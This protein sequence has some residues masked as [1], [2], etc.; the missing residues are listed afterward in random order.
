MRKHISKVLV[1]CLVMNALSSTSIY[2][3]KKT[4]EQQASLLKEQK[5]REE[6]KKELEKLIDALPARVD[7]AAEI[8]EK[9]EA[10]GF[11]E[12]VKKALFKELKEK[13]IE[14]TDEKNLLTKDNK[15]NDEDFIYDGGTKKFLAMDENSEES[16]YFKDFT[17][18]AEGEEVEVWVADDL[19][20]EKPNE[21]P[22]PK[23]TQDY[24]DKLAKEFDQNIYKK[25]TDFFGIPDERL[26]ENSMFANMENATEEEKN[27]YKA[28]D[29]KNKTI[30][31][32]DNIRDDNYYD[33]TRQEY[34]GGFYSVTLENLIDRNMVTINARM[35]EK[36]LS[37]T[38]Y[39]NDI[40][41]TTAHEFQHLIHRD[42]DEDEDTW[43]NEGMSVFAEH[44]CGYGHPYAHIAKFLIKPENSLT[45]WGD[46]SETERLQ[47]YGM[48]Y[49]FTLFLNGQY[50]KDFVKKVALDKENSL[51][52]IQNVLN[53]IGEKI[54][55]TELFHRFLVAVAIDQPKIYNGIYDIKEIDLINDVKKYIKLMLDK[56]IIDPEIYDKTMNIDFELRFNLAKYFGK[57]GV[58]AWGADFI[59]L[60]EE[61]HNQI[62]SIDFN[63]FEFQPIQ[64]KMLKTEDGNE[65]V[66]SGIGDEKDK[67]MIIK[68]D[69][70]NTTKPVLELNTLYDIEEQWDFG[71]VQVS[72]DE[73]KTWKSLSNEHTRSDVV[74]EG[75]PTIKENVPGFTGKSGNDPENAE[76]VVE[77]F[78]L[79]EYAG[80]KVYI[81]F[82]YM[83]D[84]GT[85]KLGWLIKEIA[86]VDNQE[87]PVSIYYNDCKSLKDFMTMDQ[88][89]KINKIEYAVTFIQEMPVSSWFSN[90]FT[91]IDK[92]YN[93]ITVKPFSMEK[94]DAKKIKK[95]LSTGKTYML[96]WYPSKNE[97]SDPA[98]YSYKLITYKDVVDNF[99]DNI[100]N[101]FDQELREV[102][103]QL[104]DSS[105]LLK[106]SLEN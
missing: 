47:D 58:P 21:R 75:H 55:T 52:S 71:A 25:D 38:S 83:T 31:L 84:W 86:I 32:I 51:K 42:N 45:L 96:I 93:I 98:P 66:Y 97:K 70:S 63:G 22:T 87:E 10:P 54:N 56:E 13:S 92:R 46:Y 103:K 57:D 104:I 62:E 41:G 80:Q 60:D 14:I 5:E 43:L 34:I 3:S 18:R 49:L 82:R 65:L 69:L 30:L 6:Q 8:R 33:I 76:F 17:L 50:G 35:Y 4:T 39:L 7:Y 24:V 48:V 105:D 59:A 9:E 2:A 27:Y 68:A 77:K 78:D 99:I 95:L 37:D 12:K 106:D 15:N 26:G 73:G 61:W 20:Y 100:F 74:D 101:K 53:E 29:G 102:D 16:Y 91:D 19:D 28:K 94:E 11:E 88:L 72:T 1:M 79:S 90:I 67:S 89:L 85:T 44:L 40:Y 64:W 23:V 36:V 81:N